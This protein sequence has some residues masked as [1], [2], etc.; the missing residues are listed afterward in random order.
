VH[1]TYQTAF[2]DET[3]KLE[4]RRDLYHLDSRT[5][6]AVKSGHEIVEPSSERKREPEVAAADTPRK[7]ARAHARNHGRVKRTRSVYETMYYGTSGY[8][9]SFPPRPIYR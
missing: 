9:G 2:V 1:L 7:L 6:A 3:G 4:V 5:L 8:G